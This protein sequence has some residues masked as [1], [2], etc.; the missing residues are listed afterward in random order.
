MTVST[1]NSPELSYSTRRCTS[2][3]RRY[4][5]DRTSLAR[6]LRGCRLRRLPGATGEFLRRG[7]AKTHPSGGMDVPRGRCVVAQFP[8]EGADVDVE[9]LGRTVP[10]GVPHLVHEVGPADHLAGAAHQ[11]V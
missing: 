10:V 2:T 7:E 3:S 5:A 8:S 9:R 4:A 6:R 11:R 1:A